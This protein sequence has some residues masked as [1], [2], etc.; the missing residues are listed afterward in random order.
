MPPGRRN[1][2]YNSAALVLQVIIGNK[3]CAYETEL[4]RF[5]T[6]IE[7]TKLARM[8]TILVPTDFSPA[9]ENA[10][11]FAADMARNI[12]ACVLLVHMYQLP[13]SAV[14][15]VPMMMLNADELRDE[16][17]VQLNALKER[18]EKT[19]LGSVPVFT[20]SRLGNT[21][22][23]LEDICDT[24]HPFAVVMGMHGKGGVETMVFGST[25]LNAMHHL[26]VPV[27]IIPAGSSF[28]PVLKIG[29]ACDLK[30]VEA[31]MPGKEI[32]AV[33]KEFGA[34]LHVLNV[35]K[36]FE[37]FA[38][39]GREQTTVLHTMLAGLDPRYHFIHKDNIEES[40]DDFAQRHQMDFLI[41]VPKKH[42]FPEGLFHK[43]CSKK[44]AEHAHVPVMAIHEPGMP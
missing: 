31:T 17:E 43:S 4:V 8:K 24:L 9:S 42:G 30:R 6:A 11:W 20:Q 34:E 5:Y 3:A 12:G 41:V 44:L 14:S 21:G 28:R 7:K 22:I 38:P 1:G 35:D 27:M 13:V 19:T 25:T 40:L 18:V 37:H 39:E 16:C 33:V 32:R 15:E 26:R 2:I 29:L 23:E 10:M 36:R